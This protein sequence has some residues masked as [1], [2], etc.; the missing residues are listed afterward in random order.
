MLQQDFVSETAYNYTEQ[1][2]MLRSDFGPRNGA[3][4]ISDMV[5]F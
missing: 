2:E 3:D 1:R 5:L 4:N